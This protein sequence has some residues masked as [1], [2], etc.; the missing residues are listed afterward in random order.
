MASH[1]WSINEPYEREMATAEA[2][3]G[4]DEPRRSNLSAF[5]FAA[6]FR[7]GMIG[8]MLL[9]KLHDMAIRIHKSARCRKVFIIAFIVFPI[10]F[11]VVLAAPDYVTRQPPGERALAILELVGLSTVIAVWQWAAAVWAWPAD[12]NAHTRDD[13][14]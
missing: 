3:A 14:D 6:L 10:F 11:G 9:T 1:S 2:S 7:W 4:S 5:L 13:D 8:H 12:P